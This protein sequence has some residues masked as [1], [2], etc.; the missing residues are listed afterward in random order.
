MLT[1]ISFSDSLVQMWLQFP[2]HDLT[3]EALW[4]GLFID[5]GGNYWDVPFS[6]AV[7]LASVTSDSGISYH[8][9]A[10]HNSGLPEQFDSNGNDRA[11]TRLLPGLSLKGAFAYKKD[12]DFWRS[13]A[14]K[15]KM[16]QPYD[17]FLSNPH[18][19]ASG[20]IG[21]TLPSSFAKFIDSLV[22]S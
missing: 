3:V 16:V 1:N 12:I 13:N 20:I 6:V 21:K 18:V 10:L 7:D 17:I 2:Y 8:L 11:P 9:S 14:P 19:S 15:L 22:F 4:P 5:K